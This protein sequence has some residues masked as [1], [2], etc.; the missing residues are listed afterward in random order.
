MTSISVGEMTFGELADDGMT[1][2]LK[3]RERKPSVEIR[4]NQR[5]RW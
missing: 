2:N 1:R 3:K 4:L 5:K